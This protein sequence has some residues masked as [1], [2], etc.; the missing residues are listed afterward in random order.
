MIQIF[1]T[2]FWKYYRILF[3]TPLWK[4]MRQRAFISLGNWHICYNLSCAIWQ[5]FGDY[6][7]KQIHQKS[8]RTSTNQLPSFSDQL[9][10][11]LWILSRTHQINQYM[12]YK[13]SYISHNSYK[14][15]IH[16][17]INI[18]IPILIRLNLSL[19]QCEAN[20]FYCELL[21][22]VAIICCKQNKLHKCCFIII[23][24]ISIFFNQFSSYI[25]DNP[26]KLSLF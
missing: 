2:L 25:R 19:V 15:L 14:S 17:L 7:L 21:P 1:I 11:Y 23:T 18:C 24:P 3:T 4:T 13:L 16:I 8:F 12:N 22:I 6:F 10:I 26:F 9:T 5:F 20:L